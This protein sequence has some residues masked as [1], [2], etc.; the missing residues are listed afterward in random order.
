MEKVKKTLSM[1]RLRLKPAYF[2]SSSAFLVAAVLLVLGGITVIDA[3]FPS[4]A[5]YYIDSPEDV[6]HINNDRD[7]EVRISVKLLDDDLQESSSG[8]V[9]I[10]VRNRPLLIAVCAVFLLS[11]ILAARFFFK[12]KLDRPISELRNAAEK[13]ANKD[14]DFRINYS[15]S[16]EMGELCAAFESVRRQLAENNRLVWNMLD[17]QKRVQ[18]AFAHDIR[19]PLTVTAGYVELLEEYLPQGK[20]SREK[21]EK[22]VTLIRNNLTRIE[23]FVNMMTSLQKL[24]DVRPQIKKQSAQELFDRLRENGRMICW[25]H[26]F[27]FESE[28][29]SDVLYADGAL[30]EQI[31]WN[32]L[33]NAAAYARSRVSMRCVLK[34]GRLTITVHDDGKGFSEEALR[35]AAE[36]FYTENGSTENTHFGIGL[37]FSRI[38]CERCGGEIRYG[39]D[40]G[41]SVQATLPVK[42]RAAAERVDAE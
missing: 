39:N 23:N 30:M 16:D 6:E 21:T 20:L 12:L 41:A 8:A 1:R 24:E 42:D 19:T 33:S 11:V 28:S 27:L 35:H 22:T 36:P 14:L 29:D 25:D 2:V 13:I 9:L 17:E 37:Y 40:G 32:I 15:G 5:I 7:E 26:E 31:A 10:Y 38:L 18:R 3:V 4:A 34:E